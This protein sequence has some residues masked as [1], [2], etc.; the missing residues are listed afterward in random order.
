MYFKSRI[1][2]GG[3]DLCLTKVISKQPKLTLQTVQC[4][5]QSQPHFS[6]QCKAWW[7]QTVFD[8][9]RVYQND[10]LKNVQH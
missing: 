3:Y 4:M 1:L 6:P 9:D 7:T 8:I 2:L 5:K 10:T